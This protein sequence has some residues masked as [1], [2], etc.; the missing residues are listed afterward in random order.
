MI[1]NG[2]YF[3]GAVKIVVKGAMPERFINLCM[4][5]KIDLWSIDR[6]EAGIVAWLSLPDFFKIRSL[7]RKS[8][9]QVKVVS[10]FGLPFTLKKIKNRKMLAAGFIFFLLALYA[11]SLHIW[12]IE[13]RGLKSLP[14]TKIRQIAATNG[15]EYSLP[16]AKADL[17]KIEK[18]ILLNIPEISWVGVSFNGT[19]A[20][21]EVVEKTMPR[22]E[23]KAPAHIVAQK[24]GVIEEIIA[25]TGQAVVQKG[26][27]VKKGDILISAYVYPNGE[28]PVRAKG[29]VKANVWY[30]NYAEV[31]R[32]KTVS[33]PTGNKQAAFTLKIGER[34]LNLQPFSSHN[35]AEYE[36]RTVQ[37]QITPWRNSQFN[38]ELTIDNYLE[39]TTNKREIPWEEAR[40]LA[41]AQALGAVQ[42]NIARQ[43]QILARSFE[44]VSTPDNDLV[45]VKVNVNTIE[46]IGETK[47]I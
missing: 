41:R 9:T 13:I 40:D 6:N 30:E 14:D 46:D 19:R 26:D 33:T 20:L 22:E 44:T 2:R 47:D 4:A 3:K 10:F 17:K 39:I 29:M 25:F 45:I 1:F 32:S 28:T 42:A 8:R 21:I 12:F 31:R 11:L 36:V 37:K 38:V 43:A 7:A 16:K 5:E 15:V 24:E 35:F 18:E 34:Q 27:L 23:N